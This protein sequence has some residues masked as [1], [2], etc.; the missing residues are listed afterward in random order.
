M[1]K[2]LQEKINGID[3][4]SYAIGFDYNDEGLLEYRIKEFV[5]ELVYLIPDF[6]FGIHRG[7]STDN[8]DVVF[9]IKDA[10]K[11]IYSIK[12][13]PEVA[14]IYMDGG[15]LDNHTVDDVEKK[16][17]S[18]GE[19]G[20]LLLYYILI[21]FHS[22]IPLISKIHF[23]DSNGMPVHGFDSVHVNPENKTLWLGESKLYSDGKRGLKELVKDLFEHF[24]RDYMEEEFMIISKWLTMDTKENQECNDAEYWIDLLS[25]ETS[26]KEQLDSIVVPLICTYTSNLYSEE[27]LDDSSEEFLDSFKK[28]II[29]LKKYFD[30]KNTHPLKDKIKVMVLFFPIKSKN[31]LVASLHRNLHIMQ[32]IGEY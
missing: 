3:F 2:I 31:D 22:T 28:E 18:R 5:Q 1:S 30:E 24:N 20:E 13:F 23:K 9:K 4:F 17:L 15:S 19:F 10:A 16:Y 8:K 7:A 26:L 21:N 6:A 25:R 29:D 12:G 11:A 27:V 32:Y 14:K